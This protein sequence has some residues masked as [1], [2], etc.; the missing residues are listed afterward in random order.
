MRTQMLE[1][2]FVLG[3]ACVGLVS[4]SSL[5]DPLRESVHNAVALV[6]DSPCRTFTAAADRLT[7]KTPGSFRL[8]RLARPLR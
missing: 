1:T 2:I 5:R 4:G 6:A 3:C 8:R 7:G